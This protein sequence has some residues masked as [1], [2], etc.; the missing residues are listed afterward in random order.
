MTSRISSSRAG[1]IG[2][3]CALTLASL[4]LA[5]CGSGSE[6]IVAQEG[7]LSCIECHTDRKLLKADLKADPK[8]VI[9]KAESE[10]EG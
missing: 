5:G 6:R 7:E 1:L 10:G 3:F 2:A 8:P 4:L 9:A